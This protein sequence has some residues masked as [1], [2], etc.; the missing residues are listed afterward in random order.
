[1]LIIS[2]KQTLNVATIDD[3]LTGSW[4]DL[5]CEH[6]EESCFAGTIDTEQTKALRMRSEVKSRIR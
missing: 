6:P 1:M 3:S 5:S 2:R 4:Y